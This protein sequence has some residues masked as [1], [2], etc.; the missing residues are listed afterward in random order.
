MT[1]KRKMWRNSFLSMIKKVHENSLSATWAHVFKPGNK[2]SMRIL[3]VLRSTL[4]S[5]M[6]ECLVHLK[7]H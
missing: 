4:R 5:R 2:P 6:Q 1:R 3:S 7:T